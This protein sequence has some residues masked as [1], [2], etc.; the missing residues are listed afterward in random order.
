MWCARDVAEFLNV[1][2]ATLS[3]WRREKVG[4]PFL[5]V[6]GISRYNPSSVR[7][8]VKANEQAHG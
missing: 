3:R 1:S 6:G 2:Q 4:P 8:W 5:R 7:A